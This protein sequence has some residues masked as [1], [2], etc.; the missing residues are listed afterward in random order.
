[1]SA[2]RAIPSSRLGGPPRISG[3][4]RLRPRTPALRIPLALGLA[5]RR[6]KLDVLHV[7]YIAPPAH[8]GR[9]VATIH[10]LGFLRVPQTFS[11]LFV[12]R[13][14]V[15]VRATARRAARIITGSALARADLA[16]TYGLDADRIACIPHGVAP[17][18]FGPATRPKPRASWR[19]TASAVRSS[20]P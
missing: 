13:S 15:L 5:S 12:L 16:A 2:T 9:L 6:D 4:R 14:R 8:K 1:M 19:P 7:Q 3:L 10:D 11:R 17:E 20:C 18:Y